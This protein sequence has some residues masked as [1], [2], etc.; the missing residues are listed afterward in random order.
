MSTAMSRA[1]RWARWLLPALLVAALLAVW[2]LHPP[3]E[4]APAERVAPPKPGAPVVA[5]ALRRIKSETLLYHVRSPQGV[6]LLPSVLGTATFKLT[7]DE[8]QGEPQIVL[9]A[10]AKSN[11]YPYEA[12]MTSRL[13]EADLAPLEFLN[14]RTKKSYKCRWMSFRDGVVRYFKHKHCDAPAL[15]HNPRHL[16][17]QKDGSLAHCADRKRCGNRDHFVWSLTARHRPEGRV[18]D[19]LAGVYI[20]RGF[21]V[22][23]GG[24][25]R[26]FRVASN[27]AEFDVEVKAEREETVTVPAGQI[28]CYKVAISSTPANEEAKK[29]PEA[30]DF[31]GL[32][33]T[34]DLFVDK[35]TRQLVLVRA[36]IQL[37]ISFDVEI[38]LVSRATEYLDGPPAAKP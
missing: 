19:M 6:G 28:A 5:P 11:V 37:V 27:R 29:D 38:V 12:T 18:Y 15:C 24:P 31:F 3:R 1:P 17:P 33:G 10:A 2:L 26:S 9:Q 22:V 14:E 25:G 21:D 30:S 32:H 4:A 20:P 16:I 34:T 7:R 8:S 13:S 35:V 36:K 23:P